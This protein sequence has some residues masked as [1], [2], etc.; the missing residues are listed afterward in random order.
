MIRI[1]LLALGTVFL[2]LGLLGVVLP[3][4]PTTP[5]VL[6][7]AACYVRSSRRLYAWLVGHKVFGKLIRDF[8]EQRAIPKAAKIASVATMTVMVTISALFLLKPLWTKLLVAALG[9]A[10]ALVV[11]LFPTARPR[12]EDEH[13]VLPPRTGG[14]SDSRR[15]P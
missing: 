13:G 6:L 1:V 7:A 12:S 2:G 10:G 9:A 5:F 3:G 4:L 11:L 15:I 8:Q 14:A